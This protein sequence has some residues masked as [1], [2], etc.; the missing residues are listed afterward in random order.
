V[1]AAMRQMWP[2]R[3][4]CYSVRHLPPIAR[5]GG[6]T[7]LVKWYTEQ[8]FRRDELGEEVVFTG[9]TSLT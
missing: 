2:S 3:I 8:T 6:V 5:K 1:S 7:Q 4:N 9:S